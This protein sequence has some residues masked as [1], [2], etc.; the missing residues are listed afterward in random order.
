MIECMKTAAKLPERNE[1]KTI[2][3]KENK[4]QT[5]HIYISGPITGTSDYMERFEKAEKELIENGYSVINPAK[6]NAMLPE[7]ATWEEYIKV[8]L[9]LLSICTGVYMMPGWRE[10]RGAVLEFMQARRN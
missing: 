7:D 6:V 3:E 8:S 1:E 9:T 10:S 5:E 2:E 4:K